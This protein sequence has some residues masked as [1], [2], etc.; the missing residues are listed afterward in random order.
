MQVRWLVVASMVL[1]L[2]GLGLPR[3]VEVLTCT[4]LADVV[5][6][7]DVIVR[8]KIAAIPSNGVLELEVSRYYKGGSGLTHLRAEVAG[9]RQGQR[10]DWMSDPKVG[11]ELI[12]GF[13]KRGDALV[14]EACN[15]F[16]QL[17]S[18]QELS[19]KVE[20]YIGEGQAPVGGAQP[21]PVQESRRAEL[22]RE[23]ID[24]SLNTV[25]RAAGAGLMVVGLASWLVWRWRRRAA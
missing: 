9:L 25:V 13:V 5:A 2:I 12:I 20:N 4:P 6:K 11:D 8:G 19:Q 22:G 21:Q 17:E 7:M 3:S 24:Q 1:A 15:L 16:V 14:N 10:M 23:R 18:G